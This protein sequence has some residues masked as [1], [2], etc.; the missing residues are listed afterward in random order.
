M[1]CII[2]ASHARK[3]PGKAQK[4]SSEASK[5]RLFAIGSNGQALRKK[6]LKTSFWNKI[7]DAQSARPMTL[8]LWIGMRTMII[9]MA[10]K[11]EYFAESAI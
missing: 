4:Q 8:E 6:I 7:T 10:R 2:N 5:K 1:G 11:E 3:T 9:P